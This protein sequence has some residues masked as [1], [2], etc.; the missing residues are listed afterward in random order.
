ME[1][2]WRSQYVGVFEARIADIQFYFIDNEYYFNG[3]TQ[4]FGAGDAGDQTMAQLVQIFDGAVGAG[5][6]VAGDERAPDDF[7]IHPDKG[8]FELE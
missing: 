2:S 1:L 7:A 3:H 8:N 6:V 5:A 4:V